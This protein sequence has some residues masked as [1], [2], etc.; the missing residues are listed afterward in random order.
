[1]SYSLLSKEF[2]SQVNGEHKAALSL[3]PELFPK[4]AA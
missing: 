3:N 1:M 4:N 2:A